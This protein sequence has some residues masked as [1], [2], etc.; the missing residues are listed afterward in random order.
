MS[1][2]T[3]SATNERISRTTDL[4]SQQAYTACGWAIQRGNAGSAGAGQPIWDLSAGASDSRLHFAGSSTNIQIGGNGA[5]VALKSS[6]P[7]DTWFFW[8]IKQDGSGANTLT[9]YYREPGDASFTTAQ[10]TG[11]SVTATGMDVGG[12]SG[13]NRW[14]NCDISHVKVWGAVLTDNELLAEMWSREPVRWTNLHLYWPLEDGADA[15]DFSGN[16]RDGTIT[17]TLA[18]A[19]E[20]PLPGRRFPDSDILVSAAGAETGSF[21]AG[22][23]AGATF[24]GLAAAQASVTAG[25]SADETHSGLA[26]AVASIQEALSAGETHGAIARAVASIQEGLAAGETD[27]GLATT[28][29]DFSAQITE[30]ALLQAIAQAAGGIVAGVNAGET[31]AAEAAAQGD[32]A[33]GLSAGASFTGETAGQQSAAFSAGTTNSEAFIAAV[34]AVAELTGASTYNEAF[35]S[36]AK[37]VASFS[38][39][40]SLGATFDTSAGG[41]LSG[42]ISIVAALGGAVL[43]GGSLEGSV[44]AES[45]LSG[46]TEASPNLSGDVQTDE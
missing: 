37:A 13:P 41:F 6:V 7:N 33:A 11:H 45:G 43:S 1:I 3:F 22:W 40:V 16:G 12:D 20:P 29:A 42:A 2:G 38:A 36:L 39:G 35:A 21:S 27:Q 32:I 17:G 9:G 28:L 10:Q 31:W 34:V 44:L 8:A 5:N 18:F 46:D 15:T 19:D 23:N 24:A 4:P 14:T 26:A 25:L 30:S